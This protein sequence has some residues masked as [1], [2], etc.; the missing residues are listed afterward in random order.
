MITQEDINHFD[1]FRTH[2][3]F[4]VDGTLTPS[5]GKIDKEFKSFFNSFCLSH[6]VYLVTGSDKP[7]TV[8]QIGKDTYNLCK[9]VYNCSGAEVWEGETNTYTSDW[10]PSGQQMA[11]LMQIADLS[12]Y[13]YQYGKTVEVRTGMVNFSVVGRGAVGLQ[14]KNY[15]EYD[16]EHRE[17]EKLCRLIMSQYPEL[18]AVVGGETGIDI[19]PTGNDKAQCLKHFAGEPVHFFGDACQEGGNDYAVAHALSARD[20]CIVSNVQDW[21]E[22]WEI[23]QKYTNPQTAA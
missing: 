10:K 1:N 20:D 2:Y 15:Y 18:T 22:T 23:L 5:R 4:D 3:I 19:Y 12:P 16:C 17:R 9:R 7:K 11:F 8:E 6:N 14:R 13:P 21:E